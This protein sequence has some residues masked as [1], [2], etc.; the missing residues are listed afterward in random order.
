MFKNRAVALSQAVWAVLLV[1]NI[2]LYLLWW[3]IEVEF[4]FIQLT[5][6]ARPAIYLVAV[7]L[8]FLY[9]ANRFSQLWHKMP[10]LSFMENCFLALRLAVGYGIGTIAIYFLL[11]DSGFNRSFL[12]A[13]G[14]FSAPINAFLLEKLPGLLAKRFFPEAQSLEVYLIGN[15][16]PSKDLLDYLKRCDSLGISIA[17]VFSDD[18]ELNFSYARLGNVQDFYDQTSRGEIRPSRVLSYKAEYN[19]SC[20]R[21]LVEFCYRRHIR[22]QSYA[23]YGDLFNEPVRIVHEGEHSFLA[24]INETLENP[25]NSF[26]K[27][28]LDIALA[29]PVVLFVL[30]PLFAFVWIV[31][32]FQAPGPVLFRQLRNGQNGERFTIYKFRTMYHRTATLSEEARQA[33]RF[34]PRIYPFGRWLRK[35]S[36]DEFPQFLNV[37]E[38]NMSIVGPRPLP[39]KL[40]DDLEARHYAYST[41]RY[42]KPGITGYAQV[43]G[44]RGEF[45]SDSAVNERTLKD[46]YY[47]N[48][49][50]F[51]LELMIL[52][53]TV[54]LLFA[55]QKTAY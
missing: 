21:Q 54:F 25:I 28:C 31:Q 34:D 41:R 8:S 3:K 4:S 45:M 43:H 50:S 49:W 42:V 16:K 33:T 35:L 52:V 32:R 47:I 9:A 30:P 6:S 13:Y 39:T 14:L 26:L 53:K 48:N 29:L 1:S 40:D 12:I 44:L 19:E 24:F 18:K 37:L 17:G 10:R 15:G 23:H 51:E 11:K 5:D 27:R 20:F 46:L 2:A 36:L 22:F 55:P 7:V 38:G